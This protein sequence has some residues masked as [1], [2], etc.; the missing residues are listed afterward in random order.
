MLL[1]NELFL[2]EQAKEKYKKIGYV[3]CPAFDNEKIYFNHYGIKHLVFKGRIPRPKDE[4]SIRFQLLFFSYALLKK[5]YVVDGEEK[6]V[7]GESHAYFWT[8]RLKVNNIAVRMILR[9][10]NNGTIHFF[11][12]MRE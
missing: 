2:I 12:I 9:R 6:R 5:V 10:L 4:V 8:I 3:I 7:K 11:S 1:E